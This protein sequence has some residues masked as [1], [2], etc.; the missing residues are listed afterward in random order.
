VTVAEAYVVNMLNKVRPA[1]VTH[2][3]HY[4]VLALRKCTKTEIAAARRRLEVP[5]QATEDQ[6]LSVLADKI[7]AL[8][9]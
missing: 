8:H 1:G 4:A 5:R 9:P 3:R 2:R 6:T 7:L